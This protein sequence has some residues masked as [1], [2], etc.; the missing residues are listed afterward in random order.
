MDTNLTVHPVY[1]SLTLGSTLFPTVEHAY[2]WRECIEYMRE[3]LV[4]KI[5]HCATPIEAKNIASA[6]KKH[7]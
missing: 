6:I 4:E 5:F 2:Q 1:S 7:A 3:D